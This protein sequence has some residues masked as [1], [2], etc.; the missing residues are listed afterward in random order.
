M[1]VAV[2][3]VA[4]MQVA[5]MQVAV[6]QVVVMQ[7]VVIRIGARAEWLN[8]PVQSACTRSR[9]RCVRILAR[10]LLCCI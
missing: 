8:L 6:M 7:V 5:V 4:V 3:Q 1:Q 9:A 10:L 2:M